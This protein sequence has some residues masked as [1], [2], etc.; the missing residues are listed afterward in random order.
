MDDTLGYA[1]TCTIDAGH[2][3]CFGIE[4][5]PGRSIILSRGAMIA[6]SDGSSQYRA[7]SR[8]MLDARDVPELVA[9]LEWA[10]RNATAPPSDLAQPMSF[11]SN[12]GV[13]RST[14]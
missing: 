7:A 1:D 12:D 8:L 10:M 2:N 4:S 3:G 13:P 5:E 11:G 9:A 6:M 14:R